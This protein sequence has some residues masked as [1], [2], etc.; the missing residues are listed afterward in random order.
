MNN[1]DGKVIITIGLDS[2]RFDAQIEQAE[3]E[4]AKLE[5]SYTDTANM[6]VFAG[7]QEDLRNLRLQIEKTINKLIELKNAKDRAEED[8]EEPEKKINLL[9]SLTKGVKRLAFGILGIRS[10]YTLIRKATNAYLSADEHTTKQMEANWTALGTFMETIIT[11][12]STLMKKLVTSV[13]YFASVLTGVNYIEKANTAILK[14]QTKA[15]QG[16]T[17]ANDKLKASFDEIET[18]GNKDVGGVDTGIDTSVLFDIKDIGEGTR[19]TIERIAIALKPVYEIVKQII[20]YCAK[21]PNMILVALGGVALLKTIASIIGIGGAGATAGTG[22]AGIASL[23]AYLA[24][25]GVIAIEISVIYNT[26]KEA[27]EAEKLAK[28]EAENWKN[29]LFGLYETIDA[30]TESGK[31]N[32][33]QVEQQTKMIQD[34]LEKTYADTEAI[35]ENRK[36][37]NLWDM[38]ISAVTGDW[39]RETE[40]IIENYEVAKRSIETYEKLYESGKMTDQQKKEYIETLKKYKEYLEKATYEDNT[41]ASELRAKKGVYEDAQKEL[42]KTNERLKEY[43]KETTT[44]TEKT[45]KSTIN[46]KEYAKSIEEADKKLKEMKGQVNDYNKALD[47]VKK[48]VTTKFNMDTTGAKNSINTLFDKLKNGLLTAFG[49]T[50]PTIK[51]AK[52]GIINQPNRG[53]AIGG[54][55][56]PEGVIPLT[57]SQQMSIL[58][59]AIGKYVTINATIPVYAYSRQVD[60]KVERIRAEDNFAG[61]K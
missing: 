27:R 10:A 38:I 44:S 35:E 55:G 7:Q 47:N 46:T 61:N 12:V 17:K 24:G 58:G 1:E 6:P 20:D 9:D 53:V 14:K 60:R 22:L 8:E 51:L 39:D 34:H 3:D 37:M 23:L 48:S 5:K 40:K 59:E 45:S 31:A 21:N 2:K 26:V 11:T 15:T 29:S 18:L 41:H 52:G 28:E 13:L 42:Q 56:G 36:K 54:E 32:E 30:I 19:G 25:I 49:I 4:L 57:D 33:K 50:F 16:L 43:N